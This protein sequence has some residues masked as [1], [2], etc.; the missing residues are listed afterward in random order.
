MTRT[1]PPELQKIVRGAYEALMARQCGAR[2]R[3]QQIMIGA[4]AKAVANARK[5]DEEGSGS[6]LLAINAPTGTGKTFSYLLGAV[7]IA[8]ANGLKVVISTG[9]VALMEQLERR[10]VVALKGI[11]PGMRVAVVKG[12][13]RWCCPVRA[14][15]VAE[16]GGEA[17][18]VASRLCESLAAGEWTGD[19]DEL[20]EQP[21]KAIWMRCTNDSKGCSGRKCSAYDRCPYYASRKEATEANVL[22][23]NHSMLLADI[24]AG[25]IMLPRPEDSVIVIDEAHTFPETAVESLANGDALGD[26][27]EFVIRCGMTVAGVRRAD[28]S[29]PCGRLAGQ[30]MGALEVMAG[31]LSEAQMAI[32]NLGKTTESRDESRPVRFTGG[33]LPAWLGRAAQSCRDSSEAAAQALELLMES[34]QGE[35]GDALADRTRER[36][37]SDVGAAL[38]RVD[39]ILS[40]WK[41]MAAEAGEDG[42]VAK[43]IEVS[44]EERDIRVCASPIGVGQFLHDALWKKVAASIHL[45]GTLV[46]VG[47][48]APYLRESGLDRTE[49]TVTLE[50]ESPFNHEE[51]ATL[52]V[53]RG[54]SSPKDAKAHT[55]WLKE[56]IPLML[57]KQ[58][59]GEGALVLFTSFAQ[60]REVADGMPQWVQD[61]LL[62]QDVLS[63][64][65]VVARHVQAVQGGRK[66]V[67]FGTS[68]Y[69]EGIDLPGKLCSLVVIAKLQFDVPNDPVSEE[70]RDHLASQGRDHFLE[71]S[72]PKACRR[73]AQST[74]RLIRT[75]KDKG[76]IVVA[77]PRLTGTGFGRSMVKTLPSYRLSTE[78]AMAA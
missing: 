6:R 55:Q 4:I 13:G 28:R 67:I 73:L 62:A 17:G 21:P 44:G 42:P 40:V 12:R 77:D 19:V 69:E 10:D 23:T 47:G 70:L 16:E 60:L 29:G 61:I 38:G 1:V 72:V 37:L 26:A 68:S 65:E 49:G 71:V 3:G 30:A 41:M 24:Q 7:P 20:Q 66:S 78:L 43:W 59:E 31:S 18:K 52:I 27:Q 45:S 15:Q 35:D 57:A 36:L 8:L 14:Q 56:N 25:H 48:M 46:T 9:K 51:Q 5:L 64:R 50:V 74:G 75:E 76:R 2:R 32:A 54:V 22:I 11:I 58:G 33:K 63:K 53:P 34:L 39:R